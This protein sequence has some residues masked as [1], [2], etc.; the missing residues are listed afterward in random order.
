MNTNI[1]FGISWS[2]KIW[3]L[4]LQWKHLFGFWVHWPLVNRSVYCLW[5]GRPLFLTR[6]ASVERCW[7]LSDL[8]HPL[9]RPEGI[10]GIKTNKIR[11]LIVKYSTVVCY[12]TQ[13]FAKIVQ[14]LTIESDLELFICTLE[15]GFL[16]SSFC[17]SYLSNQ[18]VERLKI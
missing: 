11:Y 4:E 5:I 13:V 17:Y 10:S 6:P 8:R 12:Q 3:R 15:K 2:F 7:W 1:N 14:E 16:T 9:C 18:V